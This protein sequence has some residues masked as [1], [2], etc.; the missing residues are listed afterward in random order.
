MTGHYY[1]LVM[2]EASSR[3][4][5]PLHRPD[6]RRPAWPPPAY[7]FPTP[8]IR[9]LGAG[10]ATQLLFG[11]CRVAVPH[12][13]PFTDSTEAD[14]WGFER[15]ALYT[16]ALRMSGEAPEPWPDLIFWCGDQVYADGS[17]LDAGPGRSAPAEGFQG[18]PD[19]A[20]DFEEYTMLYR[21]AWSRRCSVGS[22]RWSRAR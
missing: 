13:P 3:A 19:E 22:S 7:D 15:D 4:R 17:P 6:R 5:P 2:V 16:Y 8:G 9:T 20:V 18:P 1:A 10:G 11:S 21:D 14:A 12:E